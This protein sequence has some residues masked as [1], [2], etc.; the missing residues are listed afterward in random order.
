MQV[1]NNT[2]KQD[3]GFT[4]IEILVAMIILLILVGTVGFAYMRYVSQARVVAAKNQIQN[5]S[6]ALHTYFFEND[7]Y[8]TTEQGLEALWQK[9]F[10]EPVPKNWNGPYLLNKV[11]RDPWGNEYEYVSPGL[12][13][14]PFGI[15]S[16]GA[17]GLQGG[18]GDDLDIASWEE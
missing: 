14:L 18:D 4:F 15:R 11:P 12:N 8:P 1:T 5:F 13:G 3:D 2:K 17:D 9:P 10:L 7:V 6:L 16:Y